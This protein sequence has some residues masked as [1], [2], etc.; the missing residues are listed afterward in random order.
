MRDL[1]PSSFHSRASP[2]AQSGISFMRASGPR[3]L[4]CVDGSK[5]AHRPIKS[6]YRF[7]MS[8]N[9]S[10]LPC[11]CATHDSRP[12]CSQHQTYLQLETEL[13]GNEVEGREGGHLELVLEVLF[14]HAVDCPKLNLAIELAGNLVANIV[15]RWASIVSRWQ[16]RGGS[17][18]LPYPARVP[19]KRAPYCASCVS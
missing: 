19:H 12:P 4:Y 17:S 1:S 10:N 3:Q 14:G 7:A 9:F 8:I 15:F 2:R 5:R 6:R 13:G 11:A 18:A 16:P